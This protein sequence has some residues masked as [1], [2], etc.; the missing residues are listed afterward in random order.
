M[1]TQRLFV[2]LFFS[3]NI[4][5]YNLIKSCTKNLS[6][7]FIKN[8]HSSSYL[9]QRDCKPQRYAVTFAKK[10]KRLPEVYVDENSSTFNNK[11]KCLGLRTCW[12]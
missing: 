7:I 5:Y 10:N 4:L 11:A 9:S 6:K 2:I 8:I 1:E 12:Q 3:N